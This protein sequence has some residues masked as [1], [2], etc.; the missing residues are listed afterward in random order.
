MSS[1]LFELLSLEERAAYYAGTLA[2]HSTGGITPLSSMPSVL[3]FQLFGENINAAAG[4]DIWGGSNAYTGHP[5]T[6]AE[7]L[8]V[9]S[10]DVQDSAAG[11][12]A[13]NMRIMGLASDGSFLCEDVALN[14]TVGVT[15]NNRF[16]R[17]LQAYITGAVGSGG[18][19]AGTLTV[20]HSS[21]TANVFVVTDH[22]ISH[23][24]TFTVPLG[25]TAFVRR[26][27]ATIRRGA[28]GAYDRDATL[29][30]HTRPHG[31]GW[32]NTGILAVTSGFAL[33]ELPI[34]G[35]VLPA[36]CDVKITVN[37]ITPSSGTDITAG[38]EIFCIKQEF[39]P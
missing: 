13:R 9:L 3:M 6:T 20:R 26:G 5:L 21:T 12:G 34:G 27:F 39:L 37:E 2:P 31:Q 7:T 29:E 28:S 36:L 4:D 19:V 25:Y 18:E 16:W 38:L 15:T 32:R 11:T 35:F 1:H 22:G 23:N 14:G 24:A 8:Q 17:V 10:D 30:L 33:N